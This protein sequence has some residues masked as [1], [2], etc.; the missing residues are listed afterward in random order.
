MKKTKTKTKKEVEGHP[1]D[2]Y[3]KNKLIL[4]ND[5]ITNVKGILSIYLK[6]IQ[7]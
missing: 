4:D 3:G 1:E 6:Y 2:S 5:H 7:I